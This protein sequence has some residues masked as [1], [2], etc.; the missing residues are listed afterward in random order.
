MGADEVYGLF[1][2]GE[3]GESC[4]AGCGDAGEAVVAPDEVAEA[5]GGFAD[6][7]ETVEG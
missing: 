4:G 5:A 7:F 2:E 1:E 6:G 3:E